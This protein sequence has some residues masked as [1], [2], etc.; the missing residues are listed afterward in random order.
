MSVTHF[1]FIGKTTHLHM[2]KGKAHI[3][4][5]VTLHP[6]TNNHFTRRVLQSLGS[7]KNLEALDLSQ[8]ELSCEIP[9][10]LLQLS[11]LEIFNVSFNHLVGRIPQGKEFDTFDNSSYIRNLGLFGQ[12]LSKDGQDLKVPRVPPTSN[13]S[14]SLFPI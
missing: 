7:L 1:L 13:V 3:H 5:S 6:N 14:K 4:S 12:P 8:N 2:N 9:Q 10:Q 11:F